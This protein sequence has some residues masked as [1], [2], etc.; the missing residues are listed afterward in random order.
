MLTM[1]SWKR[2]WS[3]PFWSWMILRE[4]AQCWCMGWS[5]GS[6]KSC[7]KRK[8]SLLESS[9]T[10]MRIR[11]AAWPWA[12]SPS[13]STSFKS[14]LIKLRLN[15]CSRPSTSTRKR[16]SLYQSSRISCTSQYLWGRLSKV[17]AP[18]VEETRCQMNRIKAETKPAEQRQRG[19]KSFAVSLKLN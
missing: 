13:C 7:L 15:Y 14:A 12:S 4:N 16:T 9:L 11:V 6:R 5:C 10:S 17:E 8:F 1:W 19:L 2:N 18:A 3:V